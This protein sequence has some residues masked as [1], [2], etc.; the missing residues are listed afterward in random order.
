MK[1][2]ALSAV[3]FLAATAAFAQVP[4]VPASIDYKPVS[5]IR[6]GEMAV[7]QMNVEGEGDLRAFFRRTGTTEWCSVEGDNDGALSRVTLPKFDTADEIDYYFVLARERE[8][9][10]R[11]PQI[12]QAKVTNNCDTIFARHTIMLRMD[13][14]QNGAASSL[15]TGKSISNTLVT[16]TPT[17][18]SPDRP[19]P[20]REVAAGN[21]QQ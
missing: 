6:I 3:I 4:A 19:V 14:G 8:V 10:A 2:I 18:G 9:V 13:C 12:Y 16:S 7:L 17:Y 1:R 5:C 21:G 15:A 11:S 20:G